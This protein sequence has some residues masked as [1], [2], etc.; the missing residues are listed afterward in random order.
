MTGGLDRGKERGFGI[1][2]GLPGLGERLLNTVL[3]TSRDLFST[4]TQPRTPSE[5]IR[6][7]LPGTPIPISGP[8]EAKEGGLERREAPVDPHREIRAARSDVRDWKARDRSLNHE[9]VI[10]HVTSHV[11]STPLGF[12]HVR[13]DSTGGPGER[14]LPPPFIGP[15]PGPS[16][17]KRRARELAPSPTPRAP[18]GPEVGFLLDPRK[19]DKQ[20]QRDRLAEAAEARRGGRSGEASGG[21][22]V[23]ITDDDGPGPGDSPKSGPSSVHPKKRGR[24][25]S[26]FASGGEEDVDE[27]EEAALLHTDLFVQGEYVKR[28]GMAPR[29]PGGSGEKRSRQLLIKD[30]LPSGGGA[31]PSSTGGR[32][33]EVISVVDGDDEVG[34]LD[35]NLMTWWIDTPMN[36]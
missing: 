26:G 23:D 2:N 19:A 15:L 10:P 35:E 25:S 28:G 3:G 16:H 18:P 1:M 36:S 12:G 11:T 31:S 7:P 32:G 9:T 17:G 5:E 29:K 8:D 27:Y 4:F 24:S 34:P 21:A 22:V 30:C 14:P 13:D 33:K 6:P 20:A